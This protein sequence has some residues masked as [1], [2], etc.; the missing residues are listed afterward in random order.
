MKKL[1]IAVVVVILFLVPVFLQREVREKTLSQGKNKENAC[2]WMV[3]LEGEEMPLEQYVAGVVAG[4]MPAVY[5]LEALKAQAI[6]ARTYALY[7]LKNETQQLKATVAHQ[8]FYDGKQ[9]A[10]R[11][12]DEAEKY[13][14]KVQ[15]AVKETEGKIATYR[16]EP[17]SAMFHAASNGK[18]ESAR[19]YSGN[20]IPYLRSVTSPEKE[21]ETERVVTQR[22]SVSELK[23]AQ[24]TR[25][26]S[27]RVEQVTIGDEKMTGRQLREVLQLRS[28]DF[29]FKV[30]GDELVVTTRGYGHGVGMSQL[31]A[32]QMAL[33][34]KHAEEILQHYYSEIKISKATCEK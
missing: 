19:N 18:T 3:V 2:E 34:G 25:N 14:A 9:R 30:D 6:A 20:D 16:G 5:E 7:K 29:Q 8:V 33:A 13:E 15:K 23:A 26:D 32:Q 24:I 27:G 4:E 11:W 1:L 22:W 21:T 10:E 17:I 28:T 12:K 31:G